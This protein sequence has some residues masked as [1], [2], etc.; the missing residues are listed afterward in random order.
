MQFIE[1]A[2]QAVKTL[3]FHVAIGVVIAGIIWL[4]PFEQNRPAHRFLDSPAKPHPSGAVQVTREIQAYHD[5]NGWHA[6]ANTLRLEIP[7]GRGETEQEAIDELR[8]TFA[9]MLPEESWYRADPAAK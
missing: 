3:A 6:T 4:V 9:K 7:E 1:R 2:A 8:A 5:E